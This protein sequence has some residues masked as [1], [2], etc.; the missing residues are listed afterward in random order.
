MCCLY[1]LTPALI[2]VLAIDSCVCVWVCTCILHA[3]SVWAH[4]FVFE[5][6]CVCVCAQFKRTHYCSVSGTDVWYCKY[7]CKRLFRK[8]RRVMKTFLWFCNCAMLE[9]FHNSYEDSG[10]E[11]LRLDLVGVRRNASW[12]SPRWNVGM[13]CWSADGLFWHCPGEFWKWSS[14]ISAVFL[15]CTN[16]SLHTLYLLS[17]LPGSSIQFYL[18]PK[19]EDCMKEKTSKWFN[20]QCS[21]LQPL[22]LMLPAATCTGSIVVL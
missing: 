13:C 14:L 1:S 18:A 20:L 10:S 22:L 19:G 7:R 6:V 15:F 12:F 21:L 2:S 8:S 5:C 9:V 3:W 11:A 17:F 16:F 4:V